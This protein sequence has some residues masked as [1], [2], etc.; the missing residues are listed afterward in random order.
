MTEHIKQRVI[1]IANH[2]IKTNC[3]IRDAAKVYGVSK[4]TVHKDLSERLQRLDAVMYREVR[5]ILT[6][7]F[8][9]KHIKGGQATKR[10]Y[11]EANRAPMKG[12]K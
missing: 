7:H 9:E 2:Y 3:T 5:E 10:K 11:E 6:T 12:V 4:S 1:G 8:T